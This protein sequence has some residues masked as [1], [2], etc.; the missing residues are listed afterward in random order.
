[1]CKT[2]ETVYQCGHYKTMHKVCEHGNKEKREL[3][4]GEENA[5]STQSTKRKFMCEFEG[6]DKKKKL[7]REGPLGKDKV[8]QLLSV[9]TCRLSRTTRMRNDQGPVSGVWSWYCWNP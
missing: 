2:Y 8:E 5:H 6:C 3:C 1:M 7:K 4:D 9:L